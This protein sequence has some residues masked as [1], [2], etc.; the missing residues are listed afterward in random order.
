MKEHVVTLCMPYGYATPA[1]PSTESR[2]YEDIKHKVE[3][4]FDNVRNMAKEEGITDIKTE[5]FIDVQS[6]TES[7]IN[8][9]TRKNRSN[10]NCD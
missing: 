8:Y 6:I 1:A 2:Y 10:S 9:A 4:W 3:L 7:I 5:I